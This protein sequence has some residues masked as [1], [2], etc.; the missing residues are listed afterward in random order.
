[1]TLK[2]INRDLSSGYFTEIAQI[3]H[4]EYPMIGTV[5]ITRHVLSAPSGSGKINADDRN[6]SFHQKPDQFLRKLRML[7]KVFWRAIAGFLNESG[8]ES[9]EHVLLDNVRINVG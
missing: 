7:V 5:L 1:M 4:D 6:P 2:C 9:D 3:F 8:M